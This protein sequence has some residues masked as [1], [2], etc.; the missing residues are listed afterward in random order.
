[1]TKETLSDKY[2]NFLINIDA[3]GTSRR[4]V[5]RVFMSCVIGFAL[6]FA[7]GVDKGYLIWLIVGI[8]NNMLP[9]AHA[10][11][12]RLLFFTLISVTNIVVMVLASSFI[13]ENPELFLL[14]VPIA[15]FIAGLYSMFG[16]AGKLIGALGFVMFSLSCSFG[17]VGSS[18]L[19]EFFKAYGAAVISVFVVMFFAIPIPRDSII[20]GSKRKYYKLIEE[21]LLGHIEPNSM[22]SREVLLGIKDRVCEKLPEE[23]DMLIQKLVRLRDMTSMLKKYK[24][25]ST[26]QDRELKNVSRM[27]ENLSLITAL[28][29]E[30]AHR[31]AKTTD[32][33]ERF[34]AESGAIKDKILK[35]KSSKTVDKREYMYL[36]SAYYITDELEYI[37]KSVDCDK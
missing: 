5:F 25:K 19:L 17:P 32:E 10:P 11:K 21:I 9:L 26:N 16:V 15:G 2:F 24:Y 18:E 27:L 34:L 37:I 30:K 23:C 35:V 29:F 12:S 1:M 8:I 4:L 13:K 31:G 20:N 22:K 7:V 36:A 33:L 6:F 3:D 28:F 14:S